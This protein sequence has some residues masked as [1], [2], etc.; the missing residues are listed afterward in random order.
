M[1]QRLKGKNVAFVVAHEFEDIEVLAPLMRLSEEGV[2]V[3]IAT[4]PREAPPHFHPRSMNRNKPI[5]G[6]FGTTIPFEVLVEGLRWRHIETPDLSADDF[7]GC[8]FPGGFSPDYLRCDKYTLAF[9]A[10]MYRR[11]KVV[12]AIC[13][14]PQVLISVDA[15]Q[16]TDI[17]KGRPVT[18]FQAVRDDIRNAGGDYKNV[19]AIRSG[20]V[21]TAREPDDIPE[22]CQALMDALEDNDIEGV[23]DRI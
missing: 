23:Y 20:N 7:D 16:G 11:G 10:D 2:F 1:P 19:P 15:T 17:V 12:S 13:H 4:L 14:G 8:F 3:T 21:V 5:T 18:C 22:L 6:R 9:V